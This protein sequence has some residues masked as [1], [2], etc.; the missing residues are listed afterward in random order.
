MKNKNPLIEEFGSEGSEAERQDEMWQ[1]REKKML[2]E[3]DRLWLGVWGVF[4]VRIFYVENMI[5]VSQSVNLGLSFREYDD[6]NCKWLSW[7]LK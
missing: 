5:D 6:F 2:G 4:W 3:T 7:Y 1:E